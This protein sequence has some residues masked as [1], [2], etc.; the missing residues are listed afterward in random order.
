MISTQ[1]LEQQ[2]SSATFLSYFERNA[3]IVQS[4]VLFL[5]LYTKSVHRSRILDMLMMLHLKYCTTCI[6]KITEIIVQLRTQPC[7]SAGNLWCKNSYDLNATFLACWSASQHVEI[8]NE[9]LLS[10]AQAHLSCSCKFWIPS[11]C[12]MRNF[13]ASCSRSR[14]ARASLNRS[15]QITTDLAYFILINCRS[16]KGSL[17]NIY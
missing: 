5:D 15:K 16:G 3:V 4:P 8:C 6:I 17:Q 7:L 10:N 12:R 2:K 13:F 1:L 9:S 14:F 11:C